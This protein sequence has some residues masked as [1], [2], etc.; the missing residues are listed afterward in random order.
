MRAVEKGL[1][2]RSGKSVP[3]SRAASGFSEEFID[4]VR[5]RCWLLLREWHKA[6]KKSTPWT[7]SAL[8][9]LFVPI[10][11]NRVEQPVAFLV[12]A[13]FRVRVMAE[14]IDRCGMLGYN[15][16]PDFEH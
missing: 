9:V 13:F 10:I 2:R 1:H 14:K 11:E 15:P 12:H 3:V 4:F 16:T 8:Q 7:R 6:E 5:N